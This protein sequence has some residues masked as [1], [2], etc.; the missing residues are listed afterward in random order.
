MKVEW[1]STGL[2]RGPSSGASP[3]WHANAGRRPS[4]ARWPTATPSAGRGSWRLAMDIDVSVAVSEKSCCRQAPARTGCAYGGA[5]TNRCRGRHCAL[6]AQCFGNV[7]DAWHLFRFSCL[8]W[9][10]QEASACEYYFDVLVKQRLVSAMSHKRFSQSGELEQ[11]LISFAVLMEGLIYFY[12]FFLESLTP[13][14]SLSLCSAT[15]VKA[16]TGIENANA[17]NRNKKNEHLTSWVTWPTQADRTR[18]DCRQTGMQFFFQ[19][20]W[21]IDHAIFVFQ[22]SKKESGTLHS[23]IRYDVLYT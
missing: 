23:L 7:P 12:A 18:F 13:D 21:V 15:V 2:S 8:S 14:A 6:V 5:R 16:R 17:R 19:A 20:T 11:L 9:L 1:P 10:S 22:C 4:W 3:D